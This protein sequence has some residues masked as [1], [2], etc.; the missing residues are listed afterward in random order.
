MEPDDEDE[1][2]LL[3]ELAALQG[4]TTPKKKASPKKGSQ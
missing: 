1:D 3:A 2:S 4:N